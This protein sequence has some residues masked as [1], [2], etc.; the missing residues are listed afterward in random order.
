MIDVKAS[1]SLPKKA[2]TTYRSKKYNKGEPYWCKTCDRAWQYQVQFSHSQYLQD[3]P[4]LG[5]TVK[6]CYFC[7]RLKRIENDKKRKHTKS[8]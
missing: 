2:N 4:K 7:N 1:Y 3:F 6:M 8:K 5:C